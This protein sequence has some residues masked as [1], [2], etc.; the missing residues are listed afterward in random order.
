MPTETPI[1]PQPSSSESLAS[2]ITGVV[3][4]ALSVGAALARTAAA[5]TAP[6]AVASTPAASTEAPLKEIVHYSVEAAA[7]FVRLIV[8]SANPSASAQTATQTASS[9]PPGPAHPTVHAGSVL[10]IPLSIQNPTEVEMA[11][12]TFCCGSLIYQGSESGE[13]LT[14]QSFVFQ[15]NPLTIA[16]RDFEK[17]TIF[18]TTAEATAP[19]VY[20]AHIMVQGGT[21]E[22]PLTFEVLPAPSPSA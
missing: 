20:L 22:S 1:E 11:A 7:N 12:M 21:F 16:P 2:G 10:R 15:P 6:G 4:A 18:I 19:G 3:N 13:P 17:I 5:A 9:A 8:R 14:A